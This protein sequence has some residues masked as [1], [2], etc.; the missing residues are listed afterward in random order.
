MGKKTQ[1]Y[2]YHAKHG[3]I[4]EYAGYDLP[5]WYE[6]I[7]SECRRVRE[8]AGVF[9]VSHMGRVM[10]EGAGAAKFLDQVTTNDVSGL[11]VN[12][13][14]YSLLCNLEGGIIDD[15]TIFRLGSSRYLVV[16]NA[17]NREKNW[18]WLVKNQDHYNVQLKDMSDTVAMFAVQG[19]RARDILRALAGIDL[20]DIERYSASEVKVDNIPTLITRTG[21]TGEDGFEIYIWGTTTD[22]PEKAL[23]VWNKIIERGR[24]VGLHAVGLGA[25]DVL[26]LEAGMCLYG[27]DIDDKTTPVQARLMFVTRLEKDDFIGKKPIQ[28]E[29][30]KGPSKVRIGFRIIGKGI[31]RKGQEIL[32][33]AKPIG[34]VTSGTLSPTLGDSIGMGFV[35]P[36]YA[37]VGEKL[38]VRI[39]DRAVPAVVVKLPFYQRRSDDRLIVY[40]T[41]I[42]LAD[43]RKRGV[44]KQTVAV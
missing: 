41:E 27:N 16:Y 14:H 33:D 24:A 36:Q 18:K 3:N 25:R 31:P 4:V 5:V 37:K 35:K 8:H 43:F 19:P 11:G 32:S 9:D 13:G 44:Q 42:G 26:R 7:I 22:K 23:H 29:K 6:G 20:E 30:D 39:R 38:S 34:L 17:A 12:K 40:G 15:L 2:Q 10:V 28:Q 1:V 21:Y